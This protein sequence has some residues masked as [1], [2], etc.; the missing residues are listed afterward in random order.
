MKKCFEVVNFYCVG[1]LSIMLLVSQCCHATC[2]AVDATAVTTN[3]FACPYLDAQHSPR[4]EVLCT[5]YRGGDEV[6][7]PLWDVANSVRPGVSIIGPMTNVRVRTALDSFKKTN[8]AWMCSVGVIAGIQW[9]TSPASSGY[10]VKYIGSKRKQFLVG[11]VGLAEES[12]P[13]FLSRSVAIAQG[14]VNGKV[15]MCASGLDYLF[16]LGKCVKYALFA[17]EG[18]KIVFTYAIGESPAVNFLKRTIGDDIQSMSM[19]EDSRVNDP[20]HGLKVRSS[21]DGECVTFSISTAVDSP[22]LFHV[23]L[24]SLKSLFDIQESLPQGECDWTA[25]RM[26]TDEH[27]TF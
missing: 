27:M 11:E 7:G 4:G 9:R 8:N 17:G 5:F 3:S 24:R 26:P 2:I 18:R 13:T 14:A 10:Q 25:D 21:S 16:G 6:Y 19:V 1:I 20:R 15:Q 12:K 22:I 23:S